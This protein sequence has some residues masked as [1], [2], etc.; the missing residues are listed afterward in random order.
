MKRSAAGTNPLEYAA[1]A[2]LGFR[3]RWW[4]PG[5]VAA[6]VSMTDL[7]AAMARPLEAPTSIALGRRRRV[8]LVFP[9]PAGTGAVQSMVNVGKVQK[10][11]VDGQRVRLRYVLP[12][13]RSP[14]EL[15]LLLYR[16]RGPAQLHRVALLGR[17]RLPISAKPG[18]QLTLRYGGTEL[19][20]K[21][22]GRRHRRF[23]LVI[24]PGVDAVRVTVV[25]R[26]GETTEQSVKVTRPSYP[27]LLVLLR[28]EQNS[29]SAPHFR[30][31]VVVAEARRGSA[32]DISVVAPED[33]DRASKTINP[34]RVASGR[35][36]AELTPYTLGAYRL[37]AV[38]GDE[39]KLSEPVQARFALPKPIVAATTKPVATIERPSAP[40]I[41]PRRFFFD[42]SL[43]GGLLHNTGRLV[44]PLVSFSA[45]ASYR[46]GRLGSLGL[47]FGAGFARAT[48]TVP[49][50]VGLADAEAGVSLIPLSLGPFYRGPV[51][52]PVVPYALVAFALQLARSNS[53]AAWAE[54]EAQLHVAP[55]F[56]AQLG[57]ELPLGAVAIFT[58]GG[59]LYAK[60]DEAD[61]KLLAGG[62]VAQLGVRLRL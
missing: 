60:V 37:K 20:R 19:L 4:L 13:N 5:A 16:D 47:R 52:W 46:F 2:C 41:A 53:E 25:D 31:V 32:P 9:A 51:S 62:I 36:E 1:M 55:G 24:P 28:P 6:L 34:Q 27:R 3:V 48:Q 59:F 30:A 54:N 23:R 15:L 18:S 21:M 38:L 43:A 39:T 14:Q 44:S 45:G 26:K 22:G 61:V 12:R 42:L 11:K 50:P 49:A 10:L 7:P 56:L 8:D 29:P 57:A 58:Q 35:Y 17:T 33:A 40:K